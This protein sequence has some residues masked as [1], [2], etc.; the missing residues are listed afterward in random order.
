LQTS[1]RITRQTELETNM[2]GWIWVFAHLPLIVSKF[3]VTFYHP[4]EEWSTDSE[5]S[6]Y[7]CLDVPTYILFAMTHF[8]SNYWQAGELQ[9]IPTMIRA[10]LLCRSEAKLIL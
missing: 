2:P 3:V 9:F 4:H 6:G 10:V 1:F 5:L 8:G 7:L